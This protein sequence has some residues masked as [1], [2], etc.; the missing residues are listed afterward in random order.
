MNSNDDIGIIKQIRDFFVA[1]NAAVLGDVEIGAGTNI[2]PFVSIRGDVAPIYIGEN[3]S[4]QDHVMIH[5]KHT[6]PLEIADHVIIGH[7]AC[8][9]CRSVGESTLIGIGANVLDNCIIGK[10]CLIAAGAVIRPGTVIPDGKMVA[11]VPCKIIRNVSTKD[12]SYHH[13]VVHR[14]VDLAKAHSLGEFPLLRG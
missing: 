7:Q 2:W 12:M 8:V 1:G 6:V 3:C 11:G 13:D 5:C 9:H 10:N 4:I 14:Y